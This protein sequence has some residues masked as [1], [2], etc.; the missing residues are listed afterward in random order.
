MN[1][2]RDQSPVLSAKDFEGRSLYGVGREDERLGVHHCGVN[3]HEQPVAHCV[4]KN[5]D[6]AATGGFDLPNVRNEVLWYGVGFEH[7]HAIG[8]EQCSAHRV[9]PE[10]LVCRNDGTSFGNPT[11]NFDCRDV[12]YFFATKLFRSGTRLRSL[13]A[14]RQPPIAR[15]S[16]PQARGRV[17]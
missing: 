9:P 4:V 17:Q 12:K 14:T 11:Q 6:V 13:R 15:A 2:L 3:R 8:L 7:F 5:S 1:L 10:F 16:H